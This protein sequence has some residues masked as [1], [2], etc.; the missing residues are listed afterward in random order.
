[1]S[2]VDTSARH[3][4]HLWNDVELPMVPELQGLQAY[5]VVCAVEL[6]LGYAPA[7]VVQVLEQVRVVLVAPKTPANIGAVAR[8]CANFEVRLPAWTCTIHHQASGSMYDSHQLAACASEPLPKP[9]NYNVV[10]SQTADYQPMGGGA[11]MR[12]V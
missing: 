12:P 8:A 2:I 4:V 11:A 1:M 3:T 10:M 5:Q 9:L 7:Y 6:P